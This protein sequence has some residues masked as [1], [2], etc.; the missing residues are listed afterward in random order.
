DDDDDDEQIKLE[1]KCVERLSSKKI[2]EIQA[3]IL[4]KNTISFSPSIP[5]RLLPEYVEQQSEAIVQKDILIGANANESTLYLHHE[6]PDLIPLTDEFNVNLTT[7]ME[8][9]KKLDGDSNNLKRLSTL[10]IDRIRKENINNETDIVREFMIFLSD[11]IFKGPV[12]KFAK[13]LSKNEQ[14]NVYLYLFHEENLSYPKWIG[15][16]HWNEMDY[17]FGIPLRYPDKFTKQQQMLSRRMIHT[18]TT[19]ARTG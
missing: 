8:V 13:L 6:V 3:E 5:S 11:F 16:P 12:F 1:T 10:I 9:I 2:N 14:K 15:S 4:R 7:F 17:V 19:F 18:W